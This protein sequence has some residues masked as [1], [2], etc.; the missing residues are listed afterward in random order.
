MFAVFSKSNQIILLL[1]NLYQDFP[2]D[3]VV[4]NLPANTGDMGSIPG[5]ETKIP[6]AVRQL[7]P[8]S[9]MK[10]RRVATKTKL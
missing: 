4:K 2:G 8:H 5:P 10:I 3:P 1:K 6:H 9:T 7:S